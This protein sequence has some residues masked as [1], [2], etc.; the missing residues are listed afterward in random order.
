MPSSGLFRHLSRDRTDIATKKTREGWFK[1]I[2]GI[3]QQSEV[4]Y[5]F[6][7]DLEELL[8]G[9][10]VGVRTT[11]RLIA[12]VRERHGRDGL[13]H[14]TKLLDALK[15]EMISILS[16]KGDTCLIMSQHSA[17]PKPLVILVVGVNGVGK[18]TSIAKLAN[19]FKAEGKQV[20]LG[21]A[22]T[23]RPAAVEQLQIWADRIGVDVISHQA[24]SDPSGVAFDA[25][26]AA[27]ARGMDV[28]ILDTAGR[29]HSNQN[30][31][32]ELQKIYRVISKI[33]G[34]APHE[35]LLVLDAPTGQNGLLQAINFTASVGCT[36]VFLAKM[37]G[38]AKG[39]IVLAVSNEL[40]L[41][42]LYLGLGEGIDDVAPFVPQDFVE[43]LFVSP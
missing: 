37:D 5:G 7:E 31:M 29:L 8:I 30:L 28:L 19:R 39:G 43:A 35:V 41:P 38:T 40:N 16:V 24:G 26:G 42:V 34:D 18:T 12:N 33:I 21:A 32:G 22:D 9:A 1:R 20:L 25:L 23:F 17:I 27:Q 6:W 10:D 36:G 14:P 11:E 3:F 15:A 13:T 2:A 4:D